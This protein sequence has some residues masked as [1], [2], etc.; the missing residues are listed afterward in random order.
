[1]ATSGFEWLTGTALS[2][3]VMN[4][5]IYASRKLRLEPN[6]LNTGVETAGSAPKEPVRPFF[7][8]L[9]PSLNS[10]LDSSLPLLGSIKNIVERCSTMQPPLGH[11]R[12]QAT[13][14]EEF[15]LLLPLE[16]YHFTDLETLRSETAEYGWIQ[17]DAVRNVSA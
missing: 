2:E 1:M 13:Y 17:L 12:S 15:V 16:S 14:Y 9:P 3:G 5:R 11:F 6:Q 10:R 4:G 8:D 7:R